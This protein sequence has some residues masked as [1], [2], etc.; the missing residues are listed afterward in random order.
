MGHANH[1]R[2]IE[3]ICVRDS[4]RHSRVQRKTSKFNETKPPFV[5]CIPHTG[6]EDII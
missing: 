3:K 6:K 1:H 5:A 2:N 4:V